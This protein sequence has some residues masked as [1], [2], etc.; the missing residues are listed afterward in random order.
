MLSLKK[1][2]AE[3]AKAKAAQAASE[4]PTPSVNSPTPPAS[5]TGEAA[6]QQVAIFNRFKKDKNAQPVGKK[7]TPGEIRIQRDIGE[8]DGGNVAETIFPNPDDLTRFT[9]KVTPDSGFWKGAEYPFNFDIPPDYPHKPPKVTLAKTCKIYHPNINLEG[10]VCL[11]I[12]REDWKPVLDINAVIYGLIYLFY[13]PNPNDPLNHEAADLFRRDINR[14]RQVVYK[15][16]R[17]GY[18]NG[19]TFPRLV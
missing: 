9:V 13:E 3:E 2:R 14:F 1:K 12:L 15:T 16:L 17:G 4:N 6:P 5:E 19:E 8:L 7:R 10:N 11:N 18:Y